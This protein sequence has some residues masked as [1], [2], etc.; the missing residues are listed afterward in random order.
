[1]REELKYDSGYEKRQKAFHR[2][3]NHI[4]AKELWDAW[5]KSE[6]HNWTVEQTTEW[7]T[8]SVGLPQYIPNFLQNKVTGIH[9]PRLVIPIFLIFFIMKI[10]LG[11]Q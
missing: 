6:V 1:M 8:A 10:F 9:L 2:N 5:L 3:D 7:L 4:S 11:W